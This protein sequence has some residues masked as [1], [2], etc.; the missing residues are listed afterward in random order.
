ME[1]VLVRTKNNTV[2]FDTA[3]KLLAVQVDG[4]QIQEVPFELTR[5]DM[6]LM[7]SKYIELL[8]IVE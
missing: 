8:E 3:T 5:D 2:T 1:V 7:T 4:G 6:E